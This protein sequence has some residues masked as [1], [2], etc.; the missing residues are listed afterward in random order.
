MFIQNLNNYIY[1]N[2]NIDDIKEKL[3]PGIYKLNAGDNLIFERIDF[4][5]LPEILGKEHK[6]IKEKVIKREASS[7]FIGKSGFGKTLLA[8]HI[9]K[10]LSKKYPIIIIERV[11]VDILKNISFIFD[12]AVFIFDEF[13]KNF[14]NLKHPEEFDSEDF[15]Y[16]Q[17]ALLSFFD[18]VAKKHIF[19]LTANEKNKISKY[20]FNRPGRIRYVFNFEELDEDVFKEF[21]FSDE[22]IKLLKKIENT[23]FKF[24]FDLLNYLKEEK[25]AGFSIEESLKDIGVNVEIIKILCNYKPKKIK[26]KKDVY[27]I[28]SYYYNPFDNTIDVN[29]TDKNDFNYTESINCKNIKNYG[30]IIEISDKSTLI[31][32]KI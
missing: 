11:K 26:S 31:L 16:S 5:N 23:N 28:N 1:L 17:E 32:E 24:S 4:E 12:K 6:R 19:L 14:L 13:E 10:E 2:F 30:D 8:K 3:E 18:G 22:E 9:A 7:L 29:Y 21:G 25:D 20:I 27:N 15:N